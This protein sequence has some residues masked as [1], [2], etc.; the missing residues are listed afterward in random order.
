M[1]KKCNV[2]LM[3]LGLCKDGWLSNV[4]D[5]SLRVSSEPLTLCYSS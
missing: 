3:V 1:F 5:M 2:E 4:E